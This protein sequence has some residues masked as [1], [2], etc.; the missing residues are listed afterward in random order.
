MPGGLSALM[1]VTMG[2]LHPTWTNLEAISWVGSPPETLPAFLFL[3]LSGSGRG[4]RES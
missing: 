2:K 4:G 3:G 1:D